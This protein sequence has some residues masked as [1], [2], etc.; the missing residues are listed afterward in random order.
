MNLISTVLVFGAVIY[1]QG[2][3]V[4]MYELSNSFTVIVLMT[5]D[6]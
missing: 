1:L 2:F 4:E 3:R 5:I 6:L